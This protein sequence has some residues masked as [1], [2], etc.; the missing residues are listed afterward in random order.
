MRTSTRKKKRRATKTTKTRRARVTKVKPVLLRIHNYNVL[1]IKN[2]Y[3][4][5]TVQS[6]ILCGFINE[7]KD[8]IGVNHLLEHVLSNAYKKCVDFDCYSYLNRAG[9]L[10]NASTD[11]NIIQ[12]YATGLAKDIAK[13]AEYIVSITINP[14][15]SE[16][17]ISKEKKAVINELLIHLDD[18]DTQLYNKMYKEFFT[19]AGLQHMEDDKLMI[20]VIKKFDHKYLM[21]YY[22]DNYNNDNTV[23]VVSGD[24]DLAHTATLFKQLLPTHHINKPRFRYKKVDCYTNKSGIFHIRDDALASTKILFCFPT[25]FYINTHRHICLT[26]T[27]AILRELLFEHLRV[28]KNLVYNII[29]DTVNNSCGTIQELFV[30]TK[31]HNTA[32]VITET[33]LILNKYKDEDIDKE[34]IDAEK[35]RFLIKLYDT[36]YNSTELA[37]YYGPQYMYK[38]FLNTK[39]ISPQEQQDGI[40]KIT[41]KEIRATINE[42]FRFNKCMIVYSNKGASPF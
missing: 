38:H 35:Q 13:M 14:V 27:A 30:N 6:N 16:A 36:N 39:V 11:N 42:V 1:F 34:V 33:I 8:N 12:Y 19:I 7:T 37:N 17:L 2:K 24:F 40:N 10:S 9:L 29:M 23:F 18:S 20:D 22:R 28:K 21:R 15:F 32:K 31:N 25:Y 4:S 5:V 3:K 41:A 26:I